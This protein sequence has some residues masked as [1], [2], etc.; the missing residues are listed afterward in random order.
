MAKDLEEEMEQ[1]ETAAA[2]ESQLEVEAE[3]EREIEGLEQQDREAGHMH[4]KGLCS[5]TP[6][7]MVAGKRFV[8]ED[9]EF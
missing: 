8:V 3:L 6:W 2:R 7:I 5:K 4:E 1:E 9:V